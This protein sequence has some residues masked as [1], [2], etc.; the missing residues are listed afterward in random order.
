VFPASRWRIGR[1]DV[2]EEILASLLGSM[3][4]RDEADRDALVAKAAAELVAR[5]VS[6]GDALAKLQ[7]LRDIFEALS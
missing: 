5:G 1:S 6:V 2:G 7:Q 3:I 4:C